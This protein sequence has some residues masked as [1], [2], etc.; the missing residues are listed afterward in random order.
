MILV[1]I[2]WGSVNQWMNGMAEVMRNKK[3]MCHVETCMSWKWRN[4][5][6]VASLYDASKLWHHGNVGA[7]SVGAMLWRI[8]KQ[9]W[10]FWKEEVGVVAVFYCS[11]RCNRANSCGISSF[12][13]VVGDVWYWPVVMSEQF[14][15]FFFFFA[16]TPP[17]PKI[18]TKSVPIPVQMDWSYRNPIFILQTGFTIGIRAWETDR[19]RYFFL[20]HIIAQKLPI[21]TIWNTTTT[22]FL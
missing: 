5:E 15:M 2:S 22:S 18:F 10:K 1:Y 12:E 14:W 19:K 6:S 13:R 8:T 21:L 11:N 20:S 17:T 4:L 7:W 16:S 9:F 3:R